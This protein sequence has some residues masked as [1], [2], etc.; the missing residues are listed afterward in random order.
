MAVNVE[1]ALD[2]TMQP[3]MPLLFGGDAALQSE[4]QRNE[5][6]LRALLDAFTGDEDPGFPFDVVRELADR[7]RALC[8]QI[9]EEK[10]RNLNSVA[11]ARSL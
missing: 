9:G 8:D 6:A 7:N 2:Y 4:R 10:L 1:Q 5:E 3:S 11:L